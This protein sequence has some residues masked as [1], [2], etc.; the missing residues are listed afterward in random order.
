LTA[1]SVFRIVNRYS[2]AFFNT[3]SLPAVIGADDYLKVLQ[4]LQEDVEAKEAR[5]QEEIRQ[6]LEFE[7]AVR[8]APG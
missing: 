6:A 2:V 8:K 7:R 4:T 1:H 3:P 5:L